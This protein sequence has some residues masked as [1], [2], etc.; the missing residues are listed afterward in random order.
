MLPRDGQAPR[1]AGLAMTAGRRCSPARDC[2]MDDALS[3][4]MAL[5]AA[6]FL[7]RIPRKSTGVLDPQLASV[8]RSAH[9][10]P[11]AGQTAGSEAARR[12]DGQP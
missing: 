3:F 4:V 1:S 8:H 2:P 10:P 6:G 5:I 12:R 11:A 7:D 9:Q